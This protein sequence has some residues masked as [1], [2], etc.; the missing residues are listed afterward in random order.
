MRKL[1]AIIVLILAFGSIQATEV[2]THYDSLFL[3]G[4]QS[5]QE[6]NY[7][8]AIQAYSSILESGLESS[9][10]YYN[11]G[12]A[13][14]K[15]GQSTRAILFYEKALKLNPKDMDIKYNL[16][17]AN[18]LIVDKIEALP[19]PFYKGW[20]LDIINSLHVD[21]FAMLSILFLFLAVI[22]ILLFFRTNNGLI[23]RASFFLMLVFA[24]GSS[25]TFL[26]AK[27]QYTTNYTSN[28]AIVSSSR[29]SIYSAPN[30][31]STTLFIVHDGLKV[32]ILKTENQWN[33][34]MLPDGSIGWVPE[35]ALII[36]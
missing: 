20:W 7:E 12:N 24:I 27:S 6:Q 21:T 5:Y 14:Y 26:F 34:I 16:A 11:I 2:A 3:S 18:K 22:G 29:A 36:I 17:L 4:N 15:L 19:V 30:T 9:D 35:E 33:Q 28:N 8:A 10:L 1:V 25:F 23:K 13:H 32:S 31:T